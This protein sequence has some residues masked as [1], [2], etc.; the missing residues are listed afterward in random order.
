MENFFMSQEEVKTKNY[1]TATY[2]IQLAS[3]A[4]IVSKA[5]KIAMG[6]TLGTW[7]KVPGITDEMQR[8]YMGKVV[9]ITETPPLELSTQISGES[10]SYLIQIAYPDVNSGPD[11]PM[12]LTIL[13]G[14]DASTSAQ[15][16]LVDIQFSEHLTAHFHGPKYGID[17]IRSLTGTSHTEPLLLNMIKP[18]T[19]ITPEIGARIFYETALGGID[20]IKDDELLSDPDFC[21]AANRVK[22]Y[23]KASIAAYEKSGKKTIYVCNITSAVPKIT[24]TLKA[25]LDAG[26]KAV[27]MCFS[28]VGYSTFQYISE[29]CDAL[30]LGHYA[31]S[32]AS[33][34]GLMSGLSSH[35]SVGKFP[36]MAGAD[37]V[38]MNTPY[39][40]YPLTSLQYHKTMQQLTLPNYNLKPSMPICGGGVH[41]GLVPQFISDFGTDIIL[42]A[43]GAV[44]GHPLG[45]AAGVKSMRQAI[46]ASLNNI[47]LEEY[48]QNHQE[49]QIALNKFAR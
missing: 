23:N 3:D 39:G 21:R 42:A 6:Q 2:F 46:D 41:P 13:L 32:G 28:T 44:Q 25:V 8:L 24:D 29:S 37:M 22:A 43:G 1:I 47:P 30:I 4:D 33:N 10:R 35:L 34:E 18:C 40:G 20:F 38:M 15:M 27:M 31:G 12:L 11:F 26:A 45:S 48:A 17:G 14:N 7:V 36:R 19:G 5:K 9:N 16:K 49:L